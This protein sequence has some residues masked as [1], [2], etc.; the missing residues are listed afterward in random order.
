[1]SPVSILLEAGRFTPVGEQLA[2][3]FLF[4]LT[5]SAVLVWTDLGTFLIWHVGGHAGSAW[6]LDSY[7]NTESHS[8]GH[9]FSRVVR[10]YLTLFSLAVTSRRLDSNHF[11]S[12]FRA[13][14]N[15]ST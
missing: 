10:K 7:P 8:P 9:A 12:V 2:D 5:L 13:C 6:I 3:R 11:S 15:L 1:M 14:C 4:R